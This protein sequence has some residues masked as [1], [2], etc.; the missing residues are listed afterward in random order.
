MSSRKLGCLL[1]GTIGNT[2]TKRTLQKL[3][4]RL[5]RRK[6]TKVSCTFIRCHYNPS[7]PE[8]YHSEDGVLDVTFSLMTT[9]LLLYVYIKPSRYLYTSARIY[10]F[11]EIK[12]RWN[13][14]GRTA[15]LTARTFLPAVPLTLRAHKVVPA[16]FSHMRVIWTCGIFS[17]GRATWDKKICELA[18]AYF[19]GKFRKQCSFRA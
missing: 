13:F 12:E 1:L 11:G 10:H 7:D 19:E 4:G 17:C 2:S 18:L 5:E 8:A 15:I 14:Q 9:Y 16:F 6:S 3:L